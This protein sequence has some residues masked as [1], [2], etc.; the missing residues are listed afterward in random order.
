MKKLLNQ[1]KMLSNHCKFVFV[2]GGVMSGIGKGVV[3]ASLGKI[4]QFRGFKVSAVK[5]DPYL[6][7]DPG[8]LNP[9]EH[10]ECF[11]TEKVWDFRPVPESDEYVYRISEI[12][13]DF[14]T[15]GGSTRTLR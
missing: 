11:I 2:T 1:D 7:V 15:F 10:G 8:T 6:N 3:S 5:I 9:I 13:Q 14:G 12:D 4:L